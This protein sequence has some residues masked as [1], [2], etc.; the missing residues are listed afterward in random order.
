MSIDVEELLR[1]TP[2]PPMSLS[3]ASVLGAAKQD[4]VRRR[5]RFAGLAT[6]G[7]AAAAAVAITVGVVGRSES[8]PSPMPARTPTP[9]LALQD[10]GDN[11]F[12]A[13]S[14]GLPLGQITTTPVM[15]GATSQTETSGEALTVTRVD[16][17]LR[18][19]RSGASHDHLLPLLARL[20]DGGSVTMDQE[21]T[22]TVTPLPKDVSRAEQIVP[23]STLVDGG[24]TTMPDGSKAGVFWTG[25]PV[26]PSKLGIIW[27][28]TTGGEFGASSGEPPTTVM[29]T[30]GAVK[31]T[32]WEFVRG[33]VCGMTGSE[34]PAQ[35]LLV[36]GQCGET[37]FGI[38]QRSGLMVS[39]NGPISDLTGTLVTGAKDVTL[40][41][42][43][44]P[45][46]SRWVVCAVGTAAALGD[47]GPEWLYRTITWRGPDGRTHTFHPS[48]T[49]T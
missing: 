27:W 12:L 41:S 49:G 34:G 26:P 15:T 37:D 16:G 47:S 46:T 25:N 10:P 17:V 1:E 21:Q 48:P 24:G 43:Q 11:S 3:P 20:P 38:G 6:A 4:V 23:N 29:M 5:R 28:S 33:G 39:V 18:L 31:S 22:L 7:V 36:G 35:S 13:P 2:A 19:S 14:A 32:Y 44:I 45:G 9:T 42:A 8:V 30:V 40:V